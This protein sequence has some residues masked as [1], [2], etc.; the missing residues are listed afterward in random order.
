M[1]QQLHQV[2][3]FRGFST[4]TWQRLSKALFTSKEDFP[5]WPDQGHDAFFD[6]TQ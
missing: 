6:R 2:V 4:Y 5:W 1:V 3:S